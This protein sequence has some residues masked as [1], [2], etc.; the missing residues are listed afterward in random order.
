MPRREIIKRFCILQSEV[1][2]AVIDPIH[3]S[4]CFCR[5]GGF[6]KSDSHARDEDGVRNDGQA[7][8]WIERVVREA[9]TKEVAPTG[10]SGR[11]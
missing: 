6:W 1:W 4:D 10:S 8:E 7:L 2:R 9:L 3:A 5:Q 11:E